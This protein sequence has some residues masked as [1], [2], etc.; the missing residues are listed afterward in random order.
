MAIRRNVILVAVFMASLVLNSF[1]SLPANAQ[2]DSQ[3]FPE[4]RHNVTGK[5]LEYWRSNGGLATYGYPITDAQ[6]EVDP[7][8]GGTFLTQWFERNRFELH[9]ENAG[10]QYEILLGLLGNDLR[11][12][13]LQTD[14]DFQPT[15]PLPLDPTKPKEQQWYINETKHNLNFDFLDYWL[16]NGG[17]RR[18]GFPISEVHDEVDPETGMIFRVQ[19]FERARFEAHPENQPPYNILLGLLGNQIKTPRTKIEYAWKSNDATV[20]LNHPLGIVT[21]NQNNLYVVDIENNRVVKYDTNHHPL[22]T[23]GSLGSGD[24]Q[25]DSPGGLAIDSQQ[26][27]YVADRRNHR[28]QKFDANGNFLL[29][30]GADKFLSDFPSGIA[31]DKSNNVYVTNWLRGGVQKFNSQ[32]IFIG[33]F[34]SGL[35]S[36]YG[37][38]IDSQENVYVTEANG[39]SDRVHKL[40]ENGVPVALFGGIGSEDGRFFYPFGLTIDKQDIIYV[41]DSENNRVQKFDNTGKF[42]GK[43]GSVG[44]ANGQFLSPVGLATDAAGH[45]FVAD[46]NNSR[47]QQFDSSGNFITVWGNQSNETDRFKEATALSGDGQNYLYLAS[48]SCNCIYKLDNLGRYISKWGSQGSGDG[49]FQTP[50]ALAVSKQGAVYVVDAGNKRI[51]KFDANGKFLLKWGSQG[52]GDGQFNGPSQVAVDSQD[53]VFVADF[54]NNR[55]Q[56]FDSNGKFLLKWGSQGIGNGQFNQPGG[57][58]VDNSDNLWVL[59]YYGYRLQKFNNNGQFDSLLVIDQSIGPETR[60]ASLVAFDSQNN[61]YITNGSDVLPGIRKFDPF[62]KLLANWQARG[63]ANGAF[64]WIVGI[65]VDNQGNIFTVDLHHYLQPYEARIQK[66]IQH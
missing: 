10:T 16:K 50:T 17:V 22:L 56:K 58:A 38:A 66:F 62:G 30:W 1:S 5:F 46:T 44:S 14:P 21:D 13:A 43:W 48:K 41:A 40:D 24:G 4:T 20:Q 63:E 19:W 8:S 45:V 59:D 37:I 61:I 32:G 42:L 11:R 12:E 64:H 34:G 60:V 55:I 6:M 33:E 2:E 31:V 36:A 49:Q 52:Q 35:A 7:Q 3:Y 53:N 9:P 18:F 54:A 29:K 27:I 51:Q 47:I 39:Y 57:L 15:N 25:F 65:T 26:N 28:I 23:W